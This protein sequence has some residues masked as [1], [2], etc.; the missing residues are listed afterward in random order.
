MIESY[1]C[2]PDVVGL[3]SELATA[4]NAPSAAEL[5]RLGSDQFNSRTDHDE[6]KVHTLLYLSSI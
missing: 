5:I 1:P 2:L 6:V 4:R 3:L